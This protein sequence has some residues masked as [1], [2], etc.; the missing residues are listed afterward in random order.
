MRVIVTVTSFGENASQ[1]DFLIPFMEK[2]ME[3]VIGDL[4][5][6]EE[7]PID[8]S[9]LTA[10]HFTDNYQSELFAFQKAIGHRTFVTDNKIAKGHAQV[11]YVNHGEGPAADEGYHIFFSKLIP[12]SIMI[13]QLCED[14]QKID[15]ALLKNAKHE[16]NYYLRAIRHELAHVEDENNQRKWIWLQSAFNDNSFK[17]TL[18][19]HAYRLWGEYYACRRSNF[20]FDL[21]AISDEISS[22]LSNFEKAEEEI[23]NLRWQYN[24]REIDLESFIRLLHE[25]ICSAFI[26][27]C[28]FLGHTDRLYDHVAPLINPDL[29]PSRFYPY[30]KRV[31]DILRAMVSSYPDWNSPDIFDGLAQ[32]ILECIREFEIY[33]KDTDKGAY[34]SIPAIKLT[35][36]SNWKSI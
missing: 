13:G 29:H 8:T 16:K 12:M 15:S 10:V 32:I 2:T 30:M 27:C 1:F 11:I 5:S 34:Y 31:W 24:T 3:K 33:P 19:H 36:N 14:N 4:I 17:A 9:D 25:Y 26:Y 28:Y 20:F 22:V 23:C 18:R 21:D 6:L 35:A 7:P